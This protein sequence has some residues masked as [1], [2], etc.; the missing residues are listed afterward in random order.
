[1]LDDRVRMRQPVSR[2]MSPFPDRWRCILKTEV[3]AY[4]ASGAGT[5]TG[6]WVIDLNSVY[7]PWVVTTGLTPISYVFANGQPVGFTSLCNSNL[8]QN[9][10]VLKACCAVIL[11]PQSVTD[12]VNCVICPSEVNSP[13]IMAGTLA[14]R[15][16][17][18]CVFSTGRPLQSKYGLV[19][20]LRCSTVLGCPEKAYQ[21][22]LSGNF[23]GA[24]NSGPARGLYWQVLYTTGD[25]AVLGSALECEFR[26]A[27]E[28]EFFNLTTAT[29]PDS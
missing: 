24:Y 19:N 13:G 21:Y 8:Y 20:T 3:M 18:S 12:S 11:T 15:Y 16:T 22:D 2:G 7:K 23:D 14:Q 17:K 26:L 27:W 10:R 25:N 6:T 1:M 5:N 29:V 4:T 9:F 28:V